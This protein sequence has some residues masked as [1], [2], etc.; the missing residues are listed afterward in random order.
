MKKENKTIKIMACGCSSNAKRETE[1]GEWVESCAIH[2]CIEV[3]DDQ[4]DLTGRQAHCSYGQHAF[5]PS[6]TSLAFFEYRGKG[7]R[8]ERVCKHCGYL[9]TAHTE[10]KRKKIR[11][12]C[13]NF[14]SKGPAEYDVYY[15]GC[16]GWS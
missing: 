12:I 9:D 2:G 16:Y 11:N 4:P 15:C 7:S 8:H 3:A 6:S 5:K 10:D 1:T 14:E 13:N